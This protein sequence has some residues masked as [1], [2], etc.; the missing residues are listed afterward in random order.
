LPSGCTALRRR[1]TLGGVL[2]GG[3]C[4]RHPEAEGGVG[5]DT[6]A[7]GRADQQGVWL[8][9]QHFMLHTSHQE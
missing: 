9:K 4:P 3:T 2:G 7:E 8:V 6:G 5:E 1:G